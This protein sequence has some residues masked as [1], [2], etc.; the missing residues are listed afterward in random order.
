VIGQSNYKIFNLAKKLNRV[1][2]FIFVTCAINC[3]VTESW[4]TIKS[5]YLDGYILK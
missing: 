3:P 5:W 4:V 1:D 2:R